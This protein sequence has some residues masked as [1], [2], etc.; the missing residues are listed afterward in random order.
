MTV[1]GT[2]NTLISGNVGG[3]GSVSDL[4]KDGGG[5]LTLSGANTYT[6]GTAVNG[7]TL[8]VNNAL[9]S[10]T[11]TG[12]VTV[13]NSGTTLGEPAQSAGR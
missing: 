5:T 10:G 9:G 4:N 3:M 13:T 7:G 6:G 2:G 12:A 1:N 11:G 8:L